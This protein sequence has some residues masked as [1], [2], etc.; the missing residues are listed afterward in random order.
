M[1]EGTVSGAN[2]TAT[3]IRD[4]V[5][6]Q[7]GPSMP[8]GDHK[9]AGAS[10]TRPT[11]SSTPEIAIKGN[12][13]PVVGGDVT[14]ISGTTL[15]ITNTSNVTYTIDAASATVVVKGASSTLGNVAMGDTLVVQGT[16]NRTV[17]SGTASSIIDQG[18]KRTNACFDQQLIFATSGWRWVW[19]IR[20]CHRRILWFYRRI[21]SAPLRVL[22]RN[23]KSPSSFVA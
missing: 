21:F 5:A 4:G 8:G 19:W 13:E 22:G 17:R 15:T 12:G 10:S 1:V 7:G 2:V 3:V 20:R 23:N 9:F 16:V 11:S 14:A 6:K 18:I